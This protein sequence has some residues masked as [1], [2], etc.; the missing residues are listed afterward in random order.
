MQ[1]RLLSSMAK[2]YA[3]QIYGEDLENPVI[4]QNEPFSFQM[5]YRSEESMVEPIYAVIES[6]LPLEVI[7][8]YKETQLPVASP[9]FS[10]DA[11][12]YERKDIC[13]APDPLLKRQTEH[14]ILVD[15]TWGAFYYEKDEPNTLNALPLSYQSLFFTINEKEIDLPAGNHFVT[16]KLISKTTGETK[17]TET[18]HFRVMDQKLPKQSLIYS[19]WLHHD[20]IADIYNVEM[21]SDRYFEILQSFVHVARQSGMNMILMP[22]FTPPLDVMVGRERRTV[23]LVKIEKTKQ[24]YQFDF[25]LM[26]RFISLCLSEGMEYFEHSHLFT[27]WGAKHCPKIIATVNGKEERIFGWE[28]DATAIDYAEFLKSYLKAL[29]VVLTEMGIKERTWFHISDEP[30]EEHLE[31]YK[32]ARDVLRS[33]DPDIQTFDALSHYAY[34][35]KKLVDVPVVAIYDKE[36]VTLFEKNAKHFWAYY[37]G[38]EDRNGFTTRVLTGSGARLREL[39]FQMYLSGAEGFLQ[40]GFNYYYDRLSHGLYNPLVYP[41]GFAGNPGSPY[42]VYPGTDGTCIP[43]QRT[44]LMKEAI[45]DYTA[46]QALEKKMGRK[47]LVEE[48]K[49]AFGEVPYDRLL[50]DK[51]ILTMRAWI[52]EQLYK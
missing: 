29:M 17:A 32:N 6:S 47:K 11:K 19:N 27:Q 14:E 49:T 40:W 39:G 20:C 18:L 43:S 8:E 42:M 12:N 3:D 46:M 23:Q 4:F 1:T 2:V 51:E 10:M 22:A 16:I 37:T 7:S 48:F 33:V 36:Q 50:T 21:F 38:G 25:S 28:S 41:G 31:T 24:G 15:S 13:L 34:Y 45:V 44:K 5:S 30:Q 26:K 9:V 52:A 35:Q